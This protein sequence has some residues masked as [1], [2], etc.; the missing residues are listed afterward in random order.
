VHRIR[1][2]DIPSDIKREIEAVAGAPVV[3]VDHREGGYSPCLA[4]ALHLADGD[5]VFVK[6]VSAAHNPDSPGFV[7]QEIRV[8]E[9]MPAAVPSTRLRGS[10][11]DGAWVAIVIEHIDGTLPAIPWSSEQLSSALEAVGKL[12]ETIAPAFLPP[13]SDFLGGLFN[14]W[15]QLVAADTVPTEWQSLA[16]QL[17]DLE[18]RSLTL[19]DGER[20]VHNDIRHDNMLVTPEGD[21]RIIDWPYASRGVPWLDTVLW[22]PALQLEGGGE[23]NAVLASLDAKRR[24]PHDA[25]CAVVAACTGYF[26]HSGQLPDP[27]GLPT[28]RAFQRAQAETCGAWLRAL[29]D[30]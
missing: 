24:P 27:P 25:L 5:T 30:Q 18:Q 4:A 10:Y 1:W 3:G 28:V 14:R 26:V 23:P 6:A 12:G 7:R 13:A 16:G 2:D 11:D 29:L 9:Q 22:L 21:V 15:G 19:I 8:L 17:V 20:L